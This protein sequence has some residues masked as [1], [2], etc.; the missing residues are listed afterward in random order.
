MSIKDKI[1]KN[2]PWMYN[3]LRCYANRK[4]KKFITNM[5][6]VEKDPF[7]VTIKQ[8]GNKSF[9]AML[10]E[11]HPIGNNDG[12]FASIRW[13][14]DALYF[15][16][17][18]GLVPVVTFTNESMYYDETYSK[19]LDPFQYYFNPVSRFTTNDIAEAKSVIVYSGNNRLLAESLNTC[20]GYKVSEKYIQTMA[21]IMHK[22]LSLNEKTV[23]YISSEIEKLNLDTHTLAVH[24]RGTDYKNGYKNHPCYIPPEAYYP[25][26]DD[27]IKNHGMN[28]IFLATDDNEVLQEF[29]K[30]Y[31]DKV[32][33]YKDVYRGNGNIGVHTTINERKFHHYKLGLEVLRD[34][35]TLATCD[36]LIAGISQVSLSTRILK[37]SQNVSFSY[38]KVINNGINNHG[39]IYQV[40][41]K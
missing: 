12:F 35:Y 2:Y 20:V 33:Y 30:K 40:P 37:T 15:A 25:Y 8:N 29:L 11:I 18:L 41:I 14:L 9:G 6:R 24:I 22:Y 7:L 19:T 27:A 32:V 5:L 31:K 38:L 21:F 17:E 3:M 16:D 4:N 10:C 23:H 1:L 36:G 26:I 13:T 39:E 28:L 34:M